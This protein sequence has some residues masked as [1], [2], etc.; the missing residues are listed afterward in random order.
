MIE[1]ERKKRHYKD[2][3]IL[4]DLL[5]FKNIYEILYIIRFMFEKL[6]LIWIYYINVYSSF[7]KI[8]MFH[9]LKLNLDYHFNS[10]II[11]ESSI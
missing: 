6:T 7:I 5:I 10:I 1:R 8:F 4:E 9:I 11:Y 3:V 2:R